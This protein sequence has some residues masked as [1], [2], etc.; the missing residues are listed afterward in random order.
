MSQT[1]EREPISENARLWFGLTAAVAIFGLLLQALLVA[2]DQNGF[3][4]TPVSRVF[5]MF[6]FF[7]VLSNIMVAVSCALLYFN[8]DRSSAAFRWLRLTSVIGIAVTGVVYH[9]VLA[10]L[11]DL[12]GWDWVADF[13]LHTIDPILVVLGWL[14][15]GPRRLTSRRVVAL[16]FIFPA[17]YGVVTL[18]RGPIVDWYPYPFLDPRDKGYDRVALNAV[19]VAVLFV[20]LSA[21]AHEIDEWLTSRRENRRPV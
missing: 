14:V 8:P 16:T 10:D 1:P 3:F 2:R 18:I 6:F 7:T 21:G 12:H 20:S 11:L 17:V 19:I 4:A 9:G 5:N 13:I 15:F